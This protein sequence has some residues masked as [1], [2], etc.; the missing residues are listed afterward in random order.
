MLQ[1]KKTS[2]VEFK[3]KEK[4]KRKKKTKSYWSQPPFTVKQTESI[5]FHRIYSSDLSGLQTT[6][7]GHRKNFFYENRVLV[8][9]NWKHTKISRQ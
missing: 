5:Y 2:I 1:K 7:L 3:Q 4:K 6:K 8:W 9:A